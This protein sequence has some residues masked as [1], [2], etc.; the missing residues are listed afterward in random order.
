M[1]WN[2][3]RSDR[4][5]VPVDTASGATVVVIVGPRE[6]SGPDP[7]KESPSHATCEGGEPGSFGVVERLH[8]FGHGGVRALDLAVEELG[9]DVMIGTRD[10]RRLGIVLSHR[11]DELAR[12]VGRLHV[13]D[14]FLAT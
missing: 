1:S 11:A 14:A 7:A 4:V 8:E 12:G 13:R 5:R 2:R 10:R 6:L 9:H 3:P